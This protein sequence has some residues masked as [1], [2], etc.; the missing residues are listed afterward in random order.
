MDLIRRAELHIASGRYVVALGLLNEALRAQPENGYIATLIARTEV[1]LR[2]AMEQDGRGASASRESGGDVSGTRSAGLAAGRDFGSGL[3][4]PQYVKGERELDL[5]SRIRIL[6]TIATN[7]YERGSVESALQSL[8]KARLLD[9]SSSLVR[10]CE[11]ALRPALLRM[12]EGKQDIPEAS[13]PETPGSEARENLSTYLERRS[14]RESVAAAEKRTSDIARAISASLDEARI[15]ALKRRKEIERRERD[16]AMWREASR[17]PSP[18]ESP[19]APRPLQPPAP[20]TPN[21]GQSAFFTK[22]KQ[23]KPPR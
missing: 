14:L 2:Q 19:V 17:A 16:L 15:E 18:I 6:T 12:E 9:P 10:A 5:E 21:R 20:G 22:I 7:L 11:E 23:A 13:F 4:A 1:L 8:F 3:T